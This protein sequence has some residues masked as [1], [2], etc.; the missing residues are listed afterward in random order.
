MPKN[1]VLITGS[2]GFI[3]FHLSKT[4]L[5]EGFEVLGLDNLNDDYE[6][7]LKTNRL[8]A[9]GIKDCDPWNEKI[10]S[11]K[12]PNFLF[13]RADLENKSSL[14]ALGNEPIGYIIHLA[15]KTKIRA[16]ADDP[17]AYTKCNILGFLNLLEY[18]RKKSVKHLIFA[19]SSSVYGLRSSLPFS[20]NVSCDHQISVYS[21]TKKANE[22]FAHVYSYLYKIPVTGVRF[23][24]VYGPWCR[25]DMA[26]FKFTKAIL[27]NSEITL[28]HDENIVRDFTYIEDV[29]TGIKKLLLQ[30]PQPNSDWSG[31]NPDPSSS[32]APFRIFNLGNSKPEN[33]KRVIEIIENFL[34][35]RSKITYS[36]KAPEDLASTW[37]DNKDLFLKFNFKPEMELEKGLQNFVNWYRE[38]YSI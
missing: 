28:N 25:P 19:S 10:Q 6:P 3:G 20:A 32:L 29:V 22:A 17:E 2:A 35:R 33:L 27:E 36:K 18:C 31:E 26:I 12:Y 37:S 1:K 16:A 30:I 24:T 38:Y 4:L 23:F 8:K 9:L 34:K 7:L 15:A 21:A 14:E 11:E 5:E 13:Y